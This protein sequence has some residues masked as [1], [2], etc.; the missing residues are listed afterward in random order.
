[1]IAESVFI[2]SRGFFR[3]IHTFQN[4]MD[5]S[6]LMPRF[7]AC[8]LIAAAAP[9]AAQLPSGNWQYLWGD[10]FSGSTLDSTKWS[11]NYPWGTTHNHDAT[12]SSAN[13]VLGDGT[14]SLIARR[15]GTGGDFTSGAITTG[16]N[17][18]RF[19]SGYIE[20]R[21]RLPNTP[22]SWPAFWGLNDGWPPECDIMEYP[23]DTAAGVGYGLDEYHTAFH[24]R[25]TSGGNSAGAGKVNPAGIGNLSGTYH[26]FGVH[27][28]ANDYVGFYFNG[29]LVS[30]FN[31]ST[32]IAQMSS[33]YL[34]FNYAVGGWPGRPN[35][36]EWPVGHT[37]EMKIDWVRVWRSAAT[38][39]SN[40]TSTGTDE[41]RLWDTAA[42]W[43][44][45]APNLGG[46]TSNFGT[47]P[48]AAQRLDWSGRRTLSV[49]NLDGAT[50]YRFG[51]PGDRLVLGPGNGGSLSPAINL[52]AAT[53]TEHEI[54]GDLEWQGTLD[55][56]NN[57]NFPLLL[58]G[59]VLGGHGLRVNGRGVVS[60]DQRSTYSG[61]TIIN[62]GSPGPGV[63]RARGTTPFGIGGTVTIGEAGNSTTARL[64]LE[65]N[66]RVPNPVVLSGRNNS[67]AGIVSHHGSN[68]IAGTLSAQVGGSEYRIRSDAG[69]LFLAGSPALTSSATGTRTFTLDGAGDGRITGPVTN[70]SAT[71]NLV[72][73]GT[74][75]W[76]LDATNTHSGATAVQ[77]GTLVVKGS[78][79]T[80][81]ITVE[82]GA[83]LAGGGIIRG[84]LTAAAGS[85]VRI[86]G[87][88]LPAA[89]SLMENFAAYPSGGIGASPNTTG[90]VWSGVFDGTA[91]AQILDHGGDRALRVRGI[92]SGTSPWRGAVADLRKLPTG[93][94]SLNHGST[95]TYFFRVRRS[96][97]G[98]IDA[99]FGLSELPASGTPGSDTTAPWNKYAV[100]L[101]L[102]GDT[103]TS[104]LRA[105][106][107]GSGATSITSA[108]NDQWLNVWVNVNHANQTYRVATSTGTA[109]GT[110]SGQAFLFGR[111]QAATVGTSP[112]ITFG[113]HEA[114]NVPL[115]IDDL[116]FTPGS[117]LSFPFAAVPQLRGEILTCNGA[118]TL[119]A[120]ATLA[121]DLASPERHDRLSIA[122]PAQIQGTLK[123]SL[124]ATAT[125]A[126]GDVF[127]LIQASSGSISFSSLD[128]APLPQGL[129]WDSSGLSSG[130][131]AIVATPYAQWALG[132]AF[133]P[134]EDA[135]HLDPD[136]DGIPNAFEFLFGSNPLAPDPRHLPAASLRSAAAG[137]FPGA[138]PAKRY[139]SITATLR[140]QTGGL[141]PVA[142]AAPTPELLGAPGSSDA[143]H[144]RTLTDLGDFEIHEWTHSIPVD[145]S[146]AKF[147]RL[148]LPLN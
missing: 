116:H 29:N 49:I 136:H 123:V 134:G 5:H 64:E 43:T 85:S 75:T 48:A 52:A 92:N 110:D 41:Y 90:D 147:M 54:H 47:V 8:F 63:A 31:N 60:F 132:H 82:S 130:T 109:D 135:P 37:D 112:L 143:I 81:S 148:S 73:T 71:V 14:M 67:S 79:G 103:A 28:I 21:I 124:E 25:N 2:M 94:F 119:P 3:L 146:P 72:K 26:T 93:N 122:G 88:G 78:S 18:Q 99:I 27:W 66:T 141:D 50:R 32:A 69:N 138:D 98:P 4:P 131:L 12:M 142:Q 128:L 107:G 95:G 121:F 97:T 105:N 33:M 77:A 10:D 19:S 120:T 133:K 38:K 126:A 108:P 76:T 117:D 11:Y 59:S 1:M 100:T 36:T 68:L 58:T 9:L 55:I 129:A 34:I 87:D 23:V 139:L 144:H 84:A 65:N 53:T 114:L 30:S 113:V 20:A 6:R 62:S 89:F 51:W 56:N 17:R 44:N 106:A 70:G 40:W 101:S 118:L 115:E 61:P 22:G 42:H 91:N 125:P 46:V 16:Y 111:R 13:A 80:G 104:T 57:S 7:A 15:N 140:K 35:T 83:T 145:E 86:G 24:Y 96:G 102:F 137:D 45:G 74:G 39:T 127:Q